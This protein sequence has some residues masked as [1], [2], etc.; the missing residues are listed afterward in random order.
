MVALHVTPFKR[1]S[2]RSVFGLNEL[3]FDGGPSIVQR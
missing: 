3:L 1:Y 2:P